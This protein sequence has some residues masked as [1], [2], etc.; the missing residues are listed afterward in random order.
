GTH[1]FSGIVGMDMLYLAVFPHQKDGVLND[2]FFRQAPNKLRQLVPN[3]TDKQVEAV[4]VIDCA[5]LPGGR[6]VRINAN[7]LK[8]RAICYFDPE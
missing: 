5:E 6:T 7:T 3:A 4:R 2:V 1:F 8:Q